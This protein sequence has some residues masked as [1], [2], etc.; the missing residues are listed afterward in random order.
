V[1]AHDKVAEHVLKALFRISGY[2]KTCSFLHLYFAVHA[3]SVSD[4]TE[5][6]SQIPSRRSTPRSRIL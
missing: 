4:Y 5:Y 2:W 6:P 3:S 1:V